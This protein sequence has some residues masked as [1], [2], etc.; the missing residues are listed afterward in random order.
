M[1]KLVSLLNFGIEPYQRAW[2]LQHRL[3][4]L[5]REGRVGDV[6]ILLQHTPVITIGRRG[7]ESNILV[8]PQF[9]AEQGIEVYRVER[10]GDVTYHGPGQLVGYPI[11]DLNNHRR[12]VGWYVHSLEEVLIRAL[13]DFGIAAGQ[14]QG[15]IGV[16]ADGKKIA[17]I[18]ARIE[19]WITYH[20]FALNV[21]PNMKDWELIVPCG[22]EDREVG[23][24]QYFLGH[25]PDEQTVRQ[26]VADHFAE[27]FEVELQETTLDHLL[28]SESLAE[29]QSIVH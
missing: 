22:I 16:W 13:A 12:D 6:F 1:G 25:I 7:D 15:A 11:L 8:S 21:A 26:S 2:D 10:G 14:V 9:L 28:P 24:M 23:S 19:H 5:R 3:V 29:Q 18:G 4:A 27:V 20:G 17:A